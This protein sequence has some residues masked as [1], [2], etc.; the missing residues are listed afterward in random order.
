MFITVF[1]SKE[2]TYQTWSSYFCLSENGN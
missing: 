1:I 2:T